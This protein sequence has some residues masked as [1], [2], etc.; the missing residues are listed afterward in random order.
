VK[1]SQDELEVFIDLPAAPPGEG[2]AKRTI[3]L[4]LRISNRL[5][6]ER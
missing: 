4:V 2:G 3:D 6:A 5:A 1:K